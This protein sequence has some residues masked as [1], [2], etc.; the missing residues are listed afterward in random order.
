MAMAASGSP[1]WATDFGTGDPQGYGLDLGDQNMYETAM[2]KMF[3]G[4]FPAAVQG[5]ENAISLMPQYQSAANQ[6]A[7]TLNPANVQANIGNVFNRNLQQAGQAAN[8]AS[9]GAASAG[10][11]SGAQEGAAQDVY[12]QANAEN[13]AYLGQILSPEGIQNT[14]NAYLG[15]VSNAMQNPALQN[16]SELIGMSPEHK[17]STATTFGSVL[18]DVAGMAGGLGELGGDSGGDDA[19]ASPAYSLAP[20]SDP[21][22]GAAGDIY[23][24]GGVFTPATAGGTADTDISGLF[25]ETGTGGMSSP[26]VD[27]SALLST[28][29][30]TPSVATPSVAAPT[31]TETGPSYD[32]GEG[33]WRGESLEIVPI[34]GGGF[35]IVTSTDEH[36]NE[37]TPNPM[38]PE[39]AG[40][41]A[42]LAAAQAA[43]FR[44]T[45][46]K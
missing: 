4:E 22:T 21:G 27:T 10:L 29:A 17:Q 20:D 38:N 14:Y 31:F 5:E 35:S 1:W 41:Y 25:G 42:T 23:A 45:G 12:N 2:K 19:A 30:A 7:Q 18:G 46:G 36:G 37:I 39:N 28:G 11:S 3:L 33:G 40:H 44:L 6:E 24:G 43:L 34:P 16:M 26:L 32:P 8:Q 13:N 9:M 15:A